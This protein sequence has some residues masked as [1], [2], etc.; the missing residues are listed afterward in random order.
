MKKSALILILMFVFASIFFAESCYAKCDYYQHCPEKGYNKSSSGQQKF[1][2]KIG[3]TAL[4]EKIAE[5]R[6]REEL[7][8]ATNQ[9]FDVDVKSYSFWGFLKGRFKS[10][11]ISG[12]NLDIN[13][14]YLTSLELK[15]LC[16]YNSVRMR[17]KTI[18][19]KE[20][21]VVRFIAVIDDDDLSKTI[22]TSGYLDKLN[23]VDVKGCGITFFKLEGAGVEIKNN[24]LYFKVKITSQLFLPKPLEVVLETDLKAE[25]GRIVF[26]RV[27][28]GDLAKGV[29]LSKV[30]SQLEA[31][32]PLAFSLNL[33]ENK[34]TKMCI[35]SVD[36]VS[37]KIII[38][39]NVFIPKN[40][41]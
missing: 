14:V 18:Q 34:N 36:I 7:R 25:N 11:S 24:K 9:K 15:T 2:N 6:I 39:G 1:S 35:N 29:D 10:I 4:A 22:H 12:E 13:G 28:L 38:E 30:A 33:L 41:K 26:T 31:M 40:T 27:N 23:C 8:E 37:D 19:F 32:N 3:V 16:D 20:N 17:K 21:M 5:K